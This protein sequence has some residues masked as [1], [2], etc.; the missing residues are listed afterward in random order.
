MTIKLHPHQEKAVSELSNGKILQGGVGTGKSLTA[1]VYFYTKVSGG[2]LEYEGSSRPVPKTPKDLYIITTA[3]KRDSLEW[4]KELA[5]LGLTPEGLE[6]TQPFKVYIDS[7]QNIKKYREVKNAFFI[8]DEQR[9]VGRGSW[10]DSFLAIAKHNEWV[11]LSATPGDTWS[12][13]IPVFLA[14]GFYPNRTAFNRRHVVF[15][16]YGGF[17]KIDRYIETKRLHRL[18]DEILVDMPFERH[19]I[20]VDEYIYADYDRKAME[21]LHKKRWNIYEEAPIEN[22]SELFSAIRR[23]TG[24]DPSRLDIVLQLMKKHPRLIIF[25]NFN[26]ELEQLRTLYEFTTVAEWNGHKHEPV[27]NAPSWVYLVQY[28]AGAEAWNCTTTD[29]MIFYSLNY[30][31]RTMEQ[32]KGRIDRMNTPYDVLYYYYILTDNFLD[33]G[34]LR[35]LKQKREFNIGALTRRYNKILKESI[36]E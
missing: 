19:T 12:D 20:R 31:Y 11:I 2:T 5:L 34:I 26:H 7:W 25:Y 22:A 35:A 1:L 9:L 30:S 33:R 8:F 24:S 16:N 10:V 32:A 29:T 28:T 3:K 6:P 17:P 18:R 21:V 23:L 27:P 36:N 13:Y 15:N 14:H 4:V